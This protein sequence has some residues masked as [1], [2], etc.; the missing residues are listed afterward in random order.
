[1]KYRKAKAT[2]K[3]TGNKIKVLRVKAGMT[4]GELAEAAKLD[5]ST[6][7]ALEN[8]LWKPKKE[9]AINL[10]LVLKRKIEPDQPDIESAEDAADYLGVEL[11]ETGRPKKPA[12]PEALENHLT[13][14]ASK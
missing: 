5:R 4:A 3:K 12:Q 7:S 8:N 6:I 2:E 11:A 13:S 14:A 9:T 1:M 10:A